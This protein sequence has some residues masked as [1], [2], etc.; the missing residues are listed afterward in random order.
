[1]RFE[2]RVQPHP[3]AVDPDLHRRHRQAHGGANQLVR[4]AAHRGH[5]E[6]RAVGFR[7]LLQGPQHPVELVAA[8]G[9]IIRSGPR[10]AQR[11][12]Q[13]VEVLPGSNPIDVQVA[14][15]HEEIGFD[16]ADPDRPGRPPGSD[17]RLF[18]QV[19]RVLR[20]TADVEGEPIDV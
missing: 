19:L 6:H 5:H 15:D 1:M 12:V 2:Q 3:R 4:H 13:H 18:R 9:R 11:I 16:G 17:E 10:I 8:G 14:Y 7:E 20:V